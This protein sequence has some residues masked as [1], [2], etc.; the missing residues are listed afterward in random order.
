MMQNAADHEKCQ[1]GAIILGSANS[2][3]HLHNSEKCITPFQLFE[4][5]CIPSSRGTLVDQILHRVAGVAPL[6]NSAIVV[7]QAH[8][9]FYERLMGV[10]SASIVAQP[11]NRGTVPAVLCGLRHLG[12]LGRNTI[13][14]VFPCDDCLV[15]DDRIIRHVEEAIAVVE[16]SVS[17]SVVL[18]LA[19][20]AGAGSYGWIEAGEYLGDLGHSLFRVRGFWEKPPA[21]QILSGRC[22]CNSLVVVARAPRLLEMIGECVP[23]LYVAFNAA[24]ASP[25][26]EWQAVEDLYRNIGSCEFSEAV[27][28]RCPAGLVVKRVDNLEPNGVGKMDPRRTV[29]NPL[30]NRGSHAVKK[31]GVFPS[32]MREMGE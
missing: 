27:L 22:L 28:S 3:N 10:P 16:A 12:K 8:H 18:G 4:Q 13:V 24:L 23:A 7:D 6:A 11:F 20:G 17:L 19:P 21:E 31:S 15:S 2:S 30:P 32:L 14:S 25:G 29:Q 1:R 9:E 5:N 26:D